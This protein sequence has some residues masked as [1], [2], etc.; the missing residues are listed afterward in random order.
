MLYSH[1]KTHSYCDH[2]QYCWWHHFSR[3]PK[4]FGQDLYLN[5]ST[6][7]APNWKKT[8]KNMNEKQSHKKK[9]SISLTALR[10]TK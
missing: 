3:N 6:Q 7:N 5:V 2:S 4:K 1:R 10:R 8:Q 9:L